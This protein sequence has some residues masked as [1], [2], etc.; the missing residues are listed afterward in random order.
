MALDIDALVAPLSED[1]PSGPDFYGDAERQAIETVFERSVGDDAASAEIDWSD[2]IARI[3]AQAGQTRDVW[4][5]V[6]LMRAAA[7]KGDFQLIVEGAELLAR[8]LEDR[9][10]DVHPQLDELGFIGRKS[11]CESLTRIGD[12]LGPLQRV[13]LLSH[14]RLGQFT[15]GDFVRFLDEGSAAEGYG[16]FRALIDATS[17]EDLE[18]LAIAIEGLEN[19]IRRTD[20]VLTENA[21]DDTSTNFEPTYEL[22]GKVRKAVRNFAPA[23]SADAENDG[24]AGLPMA[25]PAAQQGAA[26]PTA[27]GSFGGAINSRQDVERA[28]DSICAYYQRHEPGSPVPF[29]LRRA[30]EWISLDFMAVLKDIAPGGLDE[31]T[32][33]LTGPRVDNNNGDD[34]GSAS[35]DDGWSTPQKSNDGW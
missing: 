18:A 17:A 1:A 27:A 6:Y 20:T 2:I 33:I 9:W 35:S 10:A 30:R 26:A 15:A 29:V 31:A 19:A 11:P 22:I 14:A 32:R 34:A 8:L 28:L 4:L 16:M 3:V 24:D 7:R 25:N 21:D 12:F 23:A 5:P 13:A